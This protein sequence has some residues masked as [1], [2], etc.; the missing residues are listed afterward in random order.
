METIEGIR[1]PHQAP[2]LLEEHA[3]P[4]PPHRLSG[5]RCLWGQALREEMAHVR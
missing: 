1:T 4:G 5:A 3:R 2:G